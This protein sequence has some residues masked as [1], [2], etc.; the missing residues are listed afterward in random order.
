MLRGGR[1]LEQFSQLAFQSRH[2]MVFLTTTLVL[3]RGTRL[4]GLGRVVSG[5]RLYHQRRKVG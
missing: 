5:E 1:S 2:V 4:S 3:L